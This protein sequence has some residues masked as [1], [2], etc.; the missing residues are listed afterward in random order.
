MNTGNGNKQ[1][2]LNS[3]ICLTEW[4]PGHNDTI[5]SMQ[6]VDCNTNIYTY[7]Y[8]LLQQFDSSISWQPIPV[9]MVEKDQD[10]VNS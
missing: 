4:F 5:T 2:K 1:S 6:L 7:T 9:H 3:S 10:L 8:H